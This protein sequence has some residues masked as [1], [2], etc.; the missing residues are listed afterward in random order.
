MLNFAAS[1]FRDFS[2]IAASSPEVWRDICIANR[3][4]LITDLKKFQSQIDKMISLIEKNDEKKLLNYL[5]DASK[6]RQEWSE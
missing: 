5:K 2:R 4:S 3:S 6:T 1:G